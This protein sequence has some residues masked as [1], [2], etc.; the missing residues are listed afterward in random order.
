MTRATLTTLCAFSFA[1]CVDFGGFDTADTWG[2][3]A[4]PEGNLWQGPWQ[5]QTINWDCAPGTNEWTYYV[6]TDG[7]AGSIGLDIVETGDGSWSTNPAAVWDEY[8]V[9]DTNLAW[10]EDGSWDEWEL[11]LRGVST[12]GAQVADE[13]TLFQCGYHSD[14]SLSWRATMYADDGTELDCGTW[15]HRPREAYGNSCF[16]FD[17]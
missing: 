15:G 6:F 2:D 9:F 13:T 16:C 10:A 11:R 5:I 1:A 7:W 4:S 12:I 8:H 17:C 14:D 3:T